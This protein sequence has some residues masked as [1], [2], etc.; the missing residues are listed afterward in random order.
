MEKI[1]ILKVGDKVRVGFWP[2]EHFFIIDYI[3]KKKVFGTDERGVE[4]AMLKNINWQPCKAPVEKIKLLK[5][6]CYDR[7]NKLEVDRFGVSIKYYNTKIDAQFCFE[8]V[9]TEDEFLEKFE[10]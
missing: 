2:K 3:G 4:M 1:L 8:I 5:F 6:Y 7:L 9:L 10:I